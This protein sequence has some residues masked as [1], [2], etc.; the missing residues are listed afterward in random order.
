M[1]VRHE[2]RR[3]SRDQAR[4]ADA[5][6]EGQADPV[7][8]AGV[9]RQTGPKHRD[10]ASDSSPDQQRVLSLLA[11]LFHFVTFSDANS[12]D[13]NLCASPKVLDKFVR[14]RIAFTQYCGPVRA[15]LQIAR[16]RK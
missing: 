8:A 1:G 6:A 12:A 15:H 10:R 4:L 14:L 9:V 13:E 5:L 16:L 2:T 11:A 7:H 3:E